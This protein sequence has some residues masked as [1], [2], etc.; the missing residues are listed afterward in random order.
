MSN[1]KAPLESKNYWQVVEK[2][3]SPMV[4][5]ARHEDQLN[6]NFQPHPCNFKTAALARSVAEVGAAERP[7]HLGR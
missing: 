7:P 1:S 2:A 4:R 3:M 5:Q 6:E